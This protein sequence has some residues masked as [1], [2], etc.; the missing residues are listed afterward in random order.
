MVKFLF[1]ISL[2]LF[3]FTSCNSIIKNKTSNYDLVLNKYSKEDYKYKDLFNGKVTVEVIMISDEVKNALRNDIKNN[4]LQEK[5]IP[6]PIAN[7]KLSFLVAF[8]YYDT[9]LNNLDN[10]K[11]IWNIILNIE[12]KTYKPIKITKIFKSNHKIFKTYFKTNQ[13]FSTFYL[14]DFDIELNNLVGKVKL[15]FSSIETTLKV[16]WRL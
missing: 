7:D 15:M 8:Y 2:F 3:T 16:V 1:I 13:R 9:K 4:N 5:N 12:E 14:V 10:K 6:F 11:S